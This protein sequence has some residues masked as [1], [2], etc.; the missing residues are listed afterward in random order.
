[1]NYLMHDMNIAHMFLHK[2][3]FG[4]NLPTYRTENRF[5][6]SN[7]GFQV[8]FLIFLFCKK[9]KLVFI[10]K[11]KINLKKAET[12]K[13]NILTNTVNITWLVDILFYQQ[14]LWKFSPTTHHIILFLIDFYFILWKGL[15]IV[16][17]DGYYREHYICW[18]YSSSNWFS[19]MICVA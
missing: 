3:P 10:I 11:Y 15:A 18:L 19:G 12:N 5:H 1:M 16:I 2:A 7:V 4:E 8:S 13:T 9:K 17:E 14:Y 6:I